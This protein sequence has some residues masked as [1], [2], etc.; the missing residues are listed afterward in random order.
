MTIEKGSEWG[1]VV[2][3]KRDGIEARGDLARDLGI[4]G[5]DIA[6]H[7]GPWRRLPID[8]IEIVTKR[9]TGEEGAITTTG[10]VRCGRRLLADLVIVSSTAFVD[11]RRLFSRAHPND[12]RF[13]WIAI[14]ASM[15]LRQRLT[16]WR[17]TRTE[18][19]LPHPLVRAGSGTAHT[20]TFAK[21]RTLISSDG[22]RVTGVVAFEARIVPDASATHIPSL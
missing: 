6:G 7:P 12:G 2:A 4:D 9:A 3:E 14:D 8:A 19:H 21:P 10:W 18:T 13:D 17:R 1:S 11:G 15:P 5:D 16:F 20:F 22:Q